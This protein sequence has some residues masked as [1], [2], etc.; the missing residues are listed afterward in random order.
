VKK[1]K[2]IINQ[3]IPKTL[4]HFTHMEDDS[5][6]SNP[7]MSIFRDKEFKP[8]R[9]IECNDPFEMNNAP[10]FINFERNGQVNGA[11]INWYCREITK[12]DSP[13]VKALKKSRPLSEN[14]YLKLIEKEVIKSL[15][16]NSLFPLPENDIIFNEHRSNMHIWCF[17][18]VDPRSAILLWSHYARHHRGVALEFKFDQEACGDLLYRVNYPEDITRPSIFSPKEIL[19]LEKSPEE[20]AVWLFERTALSKH[21]DWRYERE[22]RFVTKSYNPGCNIFTELNSGLELI[23]GVYFGINV[24]DAK[25]KELAAIIRKASPTT[26][27]FHAKKN[28]RLIKIDFEEYLE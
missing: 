25:K 18:D 19:N 24:D 27:I 9:V 11:L 12:S 22:W 5:K 16:E 10:S 6:G 26:K 13:I 23:T 15:T 1:T 17:S 2:K 4:Y 3:K 8:S 14:E 20:K 21:R 28:R 7:A